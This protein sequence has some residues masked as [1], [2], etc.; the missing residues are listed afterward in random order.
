M[1]PI[2]EEQASVGS[3]I[4]KFIGVIAVI[5]FFVYY[6]W[7]KKSDDTESVQSIPR[8]ELKKKLAQAH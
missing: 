3:G 8:R 6:K 5:V 4:F 7:V 1:I 2:A